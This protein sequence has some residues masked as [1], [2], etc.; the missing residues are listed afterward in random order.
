MTLFP[1]TGEAFARLAAESAKGRLEPENQ[2]T[3]VT[4]PECHTAAKSL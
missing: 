4:F 2:E 3:L 1:P